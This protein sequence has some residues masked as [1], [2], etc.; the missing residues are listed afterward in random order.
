MGTFRYAVRDAFRLFAR[1]WGVSFMTLVTASSLFFLVGASSLLSLNISSIIAGVESDQVLQAF[2]DDQ[3]KAEA[4][5]V[6]MRANGNVSSVK[7]I[8]PEEAMD[9]LR[10]KM[11]EQAKAIAMVGDN[12]LPWTVEVLVTRASFVGSVVEELK[13]SD[14]IEDIVYAGNLVERLTKVSSMADRIAL[15]ILAV[16]ISICAL[17][18]FNTIRMGLYSR[19]HEIAVMLLVGATKGYVASPFVLQ[20]M[21][22]G[23]FGGIFASGMLY[24]SYMG[25]IRVIDEMLPFVKVVRN[26]DVIWQISVVIIAMG[27]TVGWFCSLLSVGRY[28]READKPL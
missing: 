24:F 18:L 5:A 28:V 27:I 9:K 8:S 20:G 6:R 14:G 7:L 13:R 1:H 4:A 15:A 16:S 11:G 23:L 21:L 22:L 19:R 12:P 10:G 2:S 25:V 26:I 17:V 3:A